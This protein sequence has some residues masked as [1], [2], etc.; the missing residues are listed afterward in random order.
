MKPTV[1]G[2]SGVNFKPIVIGHPEV[3]YLHS[4]CSL[5]GTHVSLFQD[6]NALRSIKNHVVF[7][8]NSTIHV[9]YN[10]IVVAEPVDMMC[11][12][13]LALMLIIHES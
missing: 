8:P 10:N 12:S 2:H 4:C 5:C 7:E 9:F 13:E 11:N 6:L 3:N 1:I